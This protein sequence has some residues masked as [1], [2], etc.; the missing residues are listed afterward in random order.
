MYLIIYKLLNSLFVLFSSTFSMILHGDVTALYHLFKESSDS[1][2]EGQA[3]DESPAHCLLMA[4]GCHTR[5]QLHIRYLVQYLAQGYFSII[6]FRSVLMSHILK[7]NIW[8]AP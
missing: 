1:M 8:I 7:H 4:G 6:A 2:G 3:L 5:C